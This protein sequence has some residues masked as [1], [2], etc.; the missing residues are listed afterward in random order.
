MHW[1]TVVALLTS[2]L[3]QTIIMTS[4]T[5]AA[6]DMKNVMYHLLVV[7]KQLAGIVTMVQHQRGLEPLPILERIERFNIPFSVHI[8][9]NESLST[10]VLAE[11]DSYGLD[12]RF[13][14][15]IWDS[16]RS[17]FPFTI[18]ALDKCWTI[19]YSVYQLVL[20]WRRY[21]GQREASSSN[22]SNSTN[23]WYISSYRRFILCLFCLIRLIL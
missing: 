17:R 6:E 3:H 13:S 7:S 4:N 5:D 21:F 18:C 9:H 11:I 15:I 23:L 16:L 19:V 2:R 10:R 22:A 14:S 8:D 12:R 20:I 1:P